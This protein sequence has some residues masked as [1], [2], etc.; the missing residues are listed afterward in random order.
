MRLNPNRKFCLK[1]W[2]RGGRSSTT[3]YIFDGVGW[4]KRYAHRL[5]DPIVSPGRYIIILTLR[6][7][8]STP[9]KGLFEVLKRPLATKY[10]HC[11]HVD[12]RYPALSVLISD[13][14][15][16]SRIIT[17]TQCDDK[18]STILSNGKNNEFPN[19]LVF[20]HVTLR[21]LSVFFLDILPCIQSYKY[22]LFP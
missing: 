7:F 8:A 22:C 21:V 12:V 9:T 17:T 4:R 20:P 11:Q 2:A 18:I 16:T 6:I 13:T 10:I 1:N 15:R 3:L 5:L 19:T 14:H